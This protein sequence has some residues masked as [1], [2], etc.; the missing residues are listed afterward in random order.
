MI[1]ESYACSGTGWLCHGIRRQMVTPPL[2]MPFAFTLESLL[3]LLDTLPPPLK[4]LC[5]GI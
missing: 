4:I 5:V 2:F 3:V 1:L